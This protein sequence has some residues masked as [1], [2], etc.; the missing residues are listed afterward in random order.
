MSNTLT[1]L[2]PFVVAGFQRVL[3]QTGAVL[4]S[5]NSSISADIA[6][7]GQTVEIPK[8][9]P[10]SPYTITPGPVPPALVN[11]TVSSGQL[12]MDQARAER[13]HV[14][15]EDWKAMGARGTDFRVASI[16]EAISSLVN[17]AAA[18]VHGKAAIAASYAMGSAGE[19]P[20]ASDAD[21]LADLAFF[22]DTQKAP[23]MDRSLIMNPRTF[24][25]LFKLD[26]FQRLNES[27]EGVS[28]AAGTMRDLQ[29]LSV[30]WDQG[31]ASH[32]SGTGTGYLVDGALEAG[33][34][35]LDVK[36]G[37]GTILPGDVISFADGVYQYVVK[38]FD[39]S[40]VT[41]YNELLEDVDDEVAITLVGGARNLSLHRDAIYWASRAPAE[42]PG[43][44]MADEV[45]IVSD[46][47]T[48]LGMRLAS[49]PGYHARQFELSILYG[50]EVVRPELAN[51][52]VS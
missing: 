39:D 45:Q 14:T 25:D 27:P 41:L 28:F 43:G 35:T 50:A 37:S 9:A 44:D 8:A 15:G 30:G 29:G 46:P 38:S 51:L 33:D 10:G 34:T 1:P 5:V 17:E 13:F 36:T 26:E 3:R 31:V 48:G 4:G 6:A 21:V 11:K 40:T 18:F 16:D 52:L 19:N 24:R 23:A 12:V 42:V 47:V 7:Q 22:L 32:T 2:V 49:Y 20:F